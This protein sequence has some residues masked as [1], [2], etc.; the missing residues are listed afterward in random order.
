MKIGVMKQQGLT[1]PLCWAAEMGVEG[2]MVHIESAVLPVVPEEGQDNH[3][4]YH[5]S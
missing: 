4:P 2:A 1:G 3:F 5:Q